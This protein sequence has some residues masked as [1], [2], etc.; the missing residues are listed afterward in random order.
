VCSA[1][2]Q[3]VT[4]ARCPAL[5][6]RAVLAIP[7]TEHEGGKSSHPLVSKDGLFA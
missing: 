5:E 7:C 1:V 2:G 4:I 3:G 6:K